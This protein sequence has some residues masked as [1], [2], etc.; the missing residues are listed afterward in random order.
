VLI[1]YHNFGSKHG[2]NILMF[3]NCEANNSG[4]NLW[5][6]GSRSEYV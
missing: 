3:I 6:Q 2:F 4:W 1:N 5:I